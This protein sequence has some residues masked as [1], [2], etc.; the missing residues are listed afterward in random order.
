GWDGWSAVAALLSEWGAE[1][2]GELLIVRR[3]VQAGGRSRAVVNQTPV[4]LGALVRLGELL[5]DLHGQHEHQS[6]LRPEGGLEALDRLAGLEP[7]RAQYRERL[8]EWRAATDEY[9]RLDASLR[10]YAERRDFL[11]EAARELDEARPAHGDETT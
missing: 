11:I 7:Q 2:D 6:L 3:E 4:T 10:S 9:R 8:D 1:F 5:A